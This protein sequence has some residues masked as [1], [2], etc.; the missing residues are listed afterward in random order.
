MTPTGVAW[1]V[2]GEGTIGSLMGELAGRRGKTVIGG[3][4]VEKNINNRVSFAIQLT[5]LSPHQPEVGVRA[6]TAATDIVGVVTGLCSS[7]RGLTSR[8]GDVKPPNSPVDE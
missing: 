2:V 4:V 5:S 8:S 7:K 3:P 6:V 1:G